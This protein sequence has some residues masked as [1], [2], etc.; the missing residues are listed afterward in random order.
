MRSFGIRRWGNA[1]GGATE[2]LTGTYHAEGEVSR[3]AARRAAAP[4]GA[5][6]R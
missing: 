5:A 6:P 3:A 2:I 1:P 4:A